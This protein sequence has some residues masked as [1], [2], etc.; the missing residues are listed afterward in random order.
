M[1]TTPPQF[2]DK[3]AAAAAAFRG[4]LVYGPDQGL[5]SETA[6]AAI[7][8]LAGRPADPFLLTEL[9]A[10]RIK[11]DPALLADELRALP[12]LGGRKIVVIRQAGDGVAKAVTET[13]GDPAMVNFLL[14]EA[15]E[16]PPRS[17][18]RKAFEGSAA[19][20]AVACYADDPRNLD[21]VVRDM[22][23]ARNVAIGPEAVSELVGRLGND[24][25]VSRGEV[26][27]LA[28]FAG[29]GGRLTVRDVL[30]A[31]GDNAALSID[32]L[33]FDVADGDAPG[34]DRSLARALAE[35][36]NAV[37]ILRALQRHFQRLHQAAGE[38]QSGASPD[39]AMGRLRPP[40][41]FRF[42]SRFQRQCQTWSAGQIGKAMALL[43]EAERQC[44]Q[45]GAPM[46]A[47]CQRS[48]L[49]VAAA[50]R[51]RARR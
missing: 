19:A 12:M 14:V 16:L 27:K 30:A 7:A 9:A 44:K 25:L 28:L 45:T 1:K 2:K 36:V 32:G 35:G 41:F 8:A 40:V 20:A 34:A 3:L 42:K 39:A 37:Q 11:A 21:H 43:T 33:A 10:A 17:K 48:A 22:L 51:K 5:A 13:L 46:A 26:E 24:R 29:D 38:I 50:A 18:L 4:A 15:G 47:I 31:V 49:R 6:G 23:A